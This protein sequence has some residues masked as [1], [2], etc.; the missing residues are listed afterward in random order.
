FSRGFGTVFA[1]TLSRMKDNVSDITAAVNFGNTFQNVHCQRCDWSIS[2]QDITHVTRWSLRYDLPFGGGRSWLRRG[3]LARIFGD[4][5]IAA[6]VSWDS[7]L[8]VRLTSPNDSNSFGGG[9]NVRPNLTGVSPVLDDRAITDGGLYF[10]PAAFS[11]T[12]A[13]AFGTAP[14]TIGAIRNPG[15]RNVDLLVEKRVATGRGTSLSLRLEAFNA[16]NQVQYG[17]PGTNIALATFG[18]IYFTQVNTPRQ[19][20]I[21]ARWSF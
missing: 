17:G 1:Y 21:G 14:R 6:L 15:A 10:N 20:Q 5:G 13:F 18:R 2:P 12:P 11:R 8:P 19:V 9:V 16:L 3:P 7:G 4:W